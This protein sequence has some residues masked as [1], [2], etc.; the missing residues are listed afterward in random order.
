MFDKSNTMHIFRYI[1]L[2]ILATNL[3]ISVN[4][5]QPPQSVIKGSVAIQN[6]TIHIGNGEVIQSGTIL[7]EDGKI[8]YVGPDKR[9]GDTV[10]DAKSMHVYPGLIAINT[11]IGLTEID[12][13][14]STR[15]FSEIG[16]LNPHIR[17][18]IAY[19]TD[20]K[21]IPTIRSNGV[22][23]AEIVPSSGRITGQ[24]SVVQLD[25]WN[26]EDAAYLSPNGIHM[27]WPNPYSHSKGII[28][29]N[30]NYLKQVEEL[31]Q[32]IK[33]VTSYQQDNHKKEKNLRYEAMSMVLQGQKPLYIHAHDQK[34]ILDVLEYGKSNDLKVVIVGGR[35]SWKVAKQIREYNVAVVLS[36][37]Q[38]L[39]S[40]ADTD[41]DQPFKTP[42]ILQQQG[43]L[44]CISQDGS[45]EQRNLAFQAGQAV[46]Y[47]LDQEAAISALTLNTAQILGISDRT[48]SLAKGKD[49]NIIISSGNILDPMSQKII[50]SYIQGRPV[51]LDN[52]HKALYRKFSNKYSLPESN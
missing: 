51:D 23:L 8:I 20:S 28:T 36:P 25:A 1:L 21:I 17:S 50:Q 41:I 29:P 32:Y 52:K 45:W 19:N 7:F 4:A 13:V 33:E 42:A 38:R 2:Y 16:N 47:G 9:S 18:I 48:G 27:H 39:P 6:G 40:S 24:S 46:G 22:Q 30:K 31:Y 43:V 37:T 15:D 14:R 34:A 44:W 35:D 10:V 5:Q 12:A 3:S 11:I 26:W 49:A